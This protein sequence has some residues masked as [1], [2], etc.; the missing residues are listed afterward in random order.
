MAG[1]KAIIA[2]NKIIIIMGNKNHYPVA[3]LK[4]PMDFIKAKMLNSAADI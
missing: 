4:V 3:T 1:T 2:I